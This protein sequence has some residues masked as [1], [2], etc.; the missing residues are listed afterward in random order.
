MFGV[1]ATGPQGPF[2]DSLVAETRRRGLRIPFIPITL[3]GDKIKR[4]EDSLEP[5]LTDGRMFVHPKF[6]RAHEEGREFPT[7]FMD[8][9]DCMA[10]CRKLLPKRQTMTSKIAQRED[11]IAR[12]KRAGMP[13]SDIMDR[14]AK[15]FDR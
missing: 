8:L 4:I 13:F 2:Y 14:L 12:L 9:L 6:E 15:R 3:Q 10:S 7:G 5:T 1:D 11:E